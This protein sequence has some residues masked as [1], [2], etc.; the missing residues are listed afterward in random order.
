MLAI[1]FKIKNFWFNLSDKIRFILIGGLNALISYII[2]S[3]LCLLF[4]V[5]V[6]QISL[7]LSWFF[8]SII[9]FLTQKYFVFNVKGNFIK[10]YCKCLTTWFFSYF[11]NAI[12][13][14]LL[15]KKLGFNVYLGQILATLVCAIFTYVLFKKF[16]FCKR[17]ND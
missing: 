14:E 6:Y 5:E 13:L 17:S 8:S 10:Q 16:A 15:V 3:I 7:A 12:V 11:I 9:S 2:F 4:G 1:F